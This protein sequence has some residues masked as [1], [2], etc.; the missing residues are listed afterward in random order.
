[1]ITLLHLGVF[2]VLCVVGVL[3][4][5]EQYSLIKQLNYFNL[6]STKKSEKETKIEIKIDEV[7]QHDSYD[8]VVNIV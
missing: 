7:N 3:S 2:N 1:M 5:A 8:Y 6:F 4:F